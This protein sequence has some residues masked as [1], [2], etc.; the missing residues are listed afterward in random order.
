MKNTNNSNL[1]IEP[2]P[3]FEVGDFVRWFEAYADGFLGR[4]SGWGIVQS[5]Q[6][7]PT[8]D[9]FFSYSVLRNKHGDLMTFSEDYLE[10][11]DEFETRI[12]DTEKL[13]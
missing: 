12:K 7:Y 3:R 5:V 10:S 6:T 11:K 4:D 1:K 13:K 2:K 9:D 8:F